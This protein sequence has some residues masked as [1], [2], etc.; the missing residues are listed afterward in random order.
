MGVRRAGAAR[1]D[2]PRSSRHLLL[3]LG[4]V[5]CRGRPREA[6]AATPLLP[7]ARLRSGRGGRRPVAPLPAPTAAS[8]CPLLRPAR[9]LEPG[10]RCL[11]PHRL[12]AIAG[13][14]AGELSARSP[15][16]VNREWELAPDLR[17]LGG[18]T[19]GLGPRLR[20][21]RPRVGPLGRATAGSPD[22]Q[23]SAEARRKVAF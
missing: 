13:G 21:R 18:D 20:A 15:P 6:P 7:E 9:V 3:T 8:A 19:L 4:R 5:G 1:N 12:G 16:C 22:A 2:D 11:S 10:R 14:L 17:G 23:R